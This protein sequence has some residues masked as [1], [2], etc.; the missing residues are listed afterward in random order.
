MAAGQARC[1]DGYLYMTLVLRSDGIVAWAP[2]VQR[3]TAGDATVRFGGISTDGTTV[4]LSSRA[5]DL[6]PGTTDPDVYL[7]DIPADALTAT[8]LEPVDDVPYDV[9]LTPDGTTVFYSDDFPVLVDPDL[10]V[11]PGIGQYDVATGTTSVRVG[12]FFHSTQPLSASADGSVLAYRELG[13]GSNEFYLSLPGQQTQCLGSADFFTYAVSVSDDGRYV[14]RVGGGAEVTDR[15]TSTTTAV[16]DGCYS[17]AGLSSGS[18]LSADGH[19]LAYSCAEL[20]VW[21]RTTRRATA[22]T[23]TE[24]GRQVLGAPS[25]SDD[26]RFVAFS[27][28]LPTSPSGAGT[29]L[30]DRTTGHFA[31]IATVAAD[32][33]VSGDGSTV[34]FTAIAPEQ[35]DPRI[36]DLYTWDNPA[37]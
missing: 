20:K 37:A 2:G 4:A 12:P 28:Q 36:T 18:G 11:D 17:E 23:S 22:I 9:V 35:T 3:I 33:A 10:D 25:I 29:Y 26:G 32:V 27:Y 19:Y 15:T 30:W 13:A 6:V 21:D 5:T 7:Y 1:D 31:L 8:G 34:A 14:S 16:D 24:D